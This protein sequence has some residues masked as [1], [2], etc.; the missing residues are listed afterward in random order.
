ML[1][2]YVLAGGQAL[3]MGEAVAELLADIANAARAIRALLQ[4]AVLLASGSMTR[5][6]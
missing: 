6:R 1:V 5:A 3:A 4:P 2:H